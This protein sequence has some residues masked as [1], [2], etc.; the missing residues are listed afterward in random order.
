ML[1]LDDFNR[2]FTVCFLRASMLDV[3]ADIEES[4]GGRDLKL[5]LKIENY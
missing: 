1:D 4:Q 2:I 3:L 5:D